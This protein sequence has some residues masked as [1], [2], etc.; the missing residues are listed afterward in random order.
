MSHI[1][2]TGGL[3]QPLRAGIQNAGKRLG[4]QL[5]NLLIKFAWLSMHQTQDGAAVHTQPKQSAADVFAK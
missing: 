5:L 3:A 1:H 4:V 2:H